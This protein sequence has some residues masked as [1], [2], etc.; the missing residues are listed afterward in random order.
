MEDFVRVAAVEDVP[1]GERL[2]VELE[3]IRIAV[4]NLD[5]EYYAIEDVCTHDGGPLVEGDVL[6]GGQVE[7]PRHGARFDIR[8][9]DALSMPAFEPTPCY[10]V[11]IDDGNIYLEKPY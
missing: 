7:C 1:P 4:F 8:T 6:E 2:L 9:G 10:E 3:G 5:G 11:Q